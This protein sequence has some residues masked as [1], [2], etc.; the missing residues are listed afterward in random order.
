MVG[1]K[2][3]MGMWLLSMVTAHAQAPGGPVKVESY[4]VKAAPFSEQVSTVGTL[5][6]NESVTLVA[7]TS[8][9]LVKILAQGF[10]FFSYNILPL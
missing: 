5:R 8:R 7:E 9:R 3:V 4:E 1:K 2:V 10:S 6:A